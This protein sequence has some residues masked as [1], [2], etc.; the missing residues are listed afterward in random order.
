VKRYV[1]SLV[2]MGL[3]TVFLFLR[4]G[5]ESLAGDP[6]VL[7]TEEEG[8]MAIAPAGLIDVGNTLDTG[9]SIEVV[10]PE[11]NADLRS[12]VAIIVR[13]VPNGKEVDLS[14][15][16]VEV[17]KL[18]TIDITNKVLPF[19]TRK[20]I[21]AENA[22]LPSGEHQ[23]RVTIGDVGGGISRKVFLVKIL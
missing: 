5:N 7:L 12:P 6:V 22:I 15:L 2:I 16:K 8:A 17:L 4:G 10:K 19:A 3:A 23:L 14:S 18:L 21:Q 1:K 20:G 11:Q 13:F 9:P